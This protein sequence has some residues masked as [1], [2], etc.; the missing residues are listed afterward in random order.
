MLRHGTASTWHV[1][2]LPS[3]DECLALYN[4]TPLTPCFA[5][6]AGCEPICDDAI[7]ALI[8]HDLIWWIPRPG[9]QAA[10]A[11]P[12]SRTQRASLCAAPSTPCA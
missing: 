8:M 7:R 2:A 5:N 9:L 4:A 10:R 1:L 3:G 12:S 6:A 11:S